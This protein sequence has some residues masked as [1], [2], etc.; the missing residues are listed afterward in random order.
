MD[1]SGKS[2]VAA[3][4]V[5]IQVAAGSHPLKVFFPSHSKHCQTAE[6]LY[7]FSPL[8]RTIAE[9]A[10]LLNTESLMNLCYKGVLG[11]D[12]KHNI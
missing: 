9:Q 5:E 3:F 12:T 10:F 2:S 7:L 1:L 11:P 6:A 4:L 8:S